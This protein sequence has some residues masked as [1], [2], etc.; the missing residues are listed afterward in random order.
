M[1]IE[2]SKNPKRDLD[3]EEKGVE[4]TMLRKIRLIQSI[5]RKHLQYKHLRALTAQANYL[6]KNPI[7]PQDPTEDTVR[8]QSTKQKVYMQKLPTEAWIN[9]FSFI[10]EYDQLINVSSSCKMFYE[11]CK[12]NILWLQALKFNYPRVYAKYDFNVTSVQDHNWKNLVKEKTLLVTA[13]KKLVKSLHEQKDQANALYQ[14]GK[15]GDAAK[16][17][18]DALEFMK[19]TKKEIEVETDEAIPKD[20][21]IELYKI[22]AIVLSNSSMTELKLENW[23]KAFY[24]AV[25]AKK[26]LHKI[27][28]LIGDAEVYK[29]KFNLLESKILFRMKEAWA[30]FP[31]ISFV[32]YSDH[33]V[34]GVGIGTVIRATANTDGIFK[35]SEIL[36][37]D[38][39]RTNSIKGVIINKMLTVQGTRM[40]VG[41]PCE[42]HRKITLHD[43]GHLEGARRIIDGVYSGGDV[44]EY[45]NNP[46]YHINDY[47]GY[48]SWFNGQLDGELRHHDWTWHN[49]VTAAQIFREY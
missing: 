22:T 27:R 1:E 10:A 7:K 36:M 34:E 6:Q 26:K 4:E 15:L 43:I 48:A 44:E 31:V 24:D 32:R 16:C 8:Q 25:K 2:T 3:E 39:D 29:Q 46:E 45:R 11:L 19:D 9:I 35:D 37:I 40:R 14:T 17:F 18:K 33:A 42:M 21:L 5:F 23:P 12:M 47:Y 41:G 30:N 13:M 49:D 28:D 38:Y 20:L